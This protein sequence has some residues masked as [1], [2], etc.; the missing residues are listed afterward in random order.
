LDELIHSTV[1]HVI[2]P[3]IAKVDCECSLP[4]EVDCPETSRQLM[5]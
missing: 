1:Y 3:S 5:T 2:P 4:A